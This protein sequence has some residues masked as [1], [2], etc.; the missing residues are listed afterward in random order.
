MCS[1]YNSHF[2]PFSPLWGYWRSLLDSHN[3]YG[4]Q[5]ILCPI[6]QCPSWHDCFHTFLF[7][8]R[9][10]V[11]QRG[12][13]CRSLPSSE[14]DIHVETCRSH[15]PS[16]LFYDW[17]KICLSITMLHHPM[18][19]NKGGPPCKVRCSVFSLP[20]LDDQSHFSNAESI[21]RHRGSNQL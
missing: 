16:E 9:V 7:S 4:N 17:Y 2:Q 20:L 5:S 12:F 8:S 11:V 3:L 15:F 13:G 14:Q 10:A 21:S 19:K 6:C 18:R 1:S